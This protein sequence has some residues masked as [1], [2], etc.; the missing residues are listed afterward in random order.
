MITMVLEVQ[1]HHLAEVREAMVKIVITV[2]L[3]LQVIGMEVLIRNLLEDLVLTDSVVQVHQ[4]DMAD[5][6]DQ[7]VLVLHLDQVPLVELMIL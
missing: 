1:V 4:A 7:V 5:L 3:Q 6:L 2:Q